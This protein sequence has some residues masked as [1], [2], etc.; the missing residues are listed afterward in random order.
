[1]HV[2]I[3]YLLLIYLQSYSNERIII[4]ITVFNI[5]IIIKIAGVNN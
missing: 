4:E 1:M 2:R 3:T 5:L